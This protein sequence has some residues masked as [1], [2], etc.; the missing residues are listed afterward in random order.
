MCEP[1]AT[2][3]QLY[4]E[5]FDNASGWTLSRATIT[6]NAAVA[7]DGNT[8]ADKLVDDST[9]G[10]SHYIFSPSIVTVVSGTAYTASVYVKAAGH[11]QAAIYFLTTNS[12]FTTGLAIFN[13]ST[14]TVVSNTTDNATITPMANGWYRITATKTAL[15]S[16]A[17][18][19]EFASAVNGNIYYNGDGTSGIYLW[20]A[21][22]EAGTKATSYVATVGSTA[23]RAADIMTYTVPAGIGH[24]SYT[25]DNDSAQ[26]VTATPGAYT[27]PT[28]TLTRNTIKKIQGGL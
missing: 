28:S 18:R 6:A 16:A 11:T 5:Q 8:T 13:L 27:V 15:A 10:L 20:G 26:T 22:F 14:G 1:A 17:C 21:Q 2:N 19:Y 3:L 9:A 7:P 24:M 23:A 4:S 25:Y 12:T